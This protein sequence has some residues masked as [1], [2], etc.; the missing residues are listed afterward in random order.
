MVDKKEFKDA[1]QPQTVQKLTKIGDYFTACLIKWT[2]SGEP[3]VGLNITKVHLPL[4][5]FCRTHM[6]LLYNIQSCSNLEST[7]KLNV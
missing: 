5:M 3:L 1:N 4:R 6:H 7:E 2:T